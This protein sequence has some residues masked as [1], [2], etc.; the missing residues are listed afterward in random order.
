MSFARAGVRVG[1]GMGGEHGCKLAEILAFSR[2]VIWGGGFLAVWGHFNFNF[3]ASWVGV[4]FSFFIFRGFS[5]G[6]G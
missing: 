5:S 4:H 1:G 6:C 2:G 3:S